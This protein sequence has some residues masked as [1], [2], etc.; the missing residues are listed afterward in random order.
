MK[1]KRNISRRD[2]LRVSAIATAGTAL[3]ACTPAISPVPTTGETP[4]P[5]ATASSAGGVPQVLRRR[6]P[7]PLINIWPNQAGGEDREAVYF[8]YAPPY[9]LTADGAQRQALR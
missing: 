9:W 2:F 7:N 4:A 6:V 3:A 8:A 1:Q 5:G